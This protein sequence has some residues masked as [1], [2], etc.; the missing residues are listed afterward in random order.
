MS[1]TL[2]VL[3]IDRDTEQACERCNFPNEQRARDYARSLV[4]HNQINVV[5]RAT[6]RGIGDITHTRWTEPFGDNL[7]EKL[8][9]E[10]ATA[11]EEANE[12][13]PLAE[14]AEG[15]RYTIEEMRLTFDRL[16]MRG[17]SITERWVE[18]FISLLESDLLTI[19][20]AQLH[21]AKAM[22]R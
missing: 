21:L 13:R 3:W 15:A 2:S 4:N 7:E 22:A 16:C 11:T 10:A 14:A 9:E 18:S 5:L 12:L 8:R 19:P 17:E 6:Y 1:D 20:D